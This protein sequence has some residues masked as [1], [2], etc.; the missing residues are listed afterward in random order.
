MYSTPVFSPEGL[1]VRARY[2]L[3]THYLLR[4]TPSHSVCYSFLTAVP[5]VY[6][7]RYTL[8]HTFLQNLHPCAP[9]PELYRRAE[10]EMVYT[11]TLAIAFTV[12]SIRKRAK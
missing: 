3:G 12:Q 7:V 9:Y 10:T 1:G 8:G 11:R 4:A 2:A 6:A 5:T